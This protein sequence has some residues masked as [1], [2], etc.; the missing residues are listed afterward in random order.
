MKTTVRVAVLM[1]QDR[2]IRSRKAV[3]SKLRVESH[4][5]LHIATAVLQFLQDTNYDLE[6][7][8][9]T[10]SH[11]SQT[12]HSQKRSCIYQILSHQQTTSTIYYMFATSIG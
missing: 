5:Y 11:N 10:N 4:L 3:A 2:R 1:Q 12:P 7:H 8:S 9:L 6:S